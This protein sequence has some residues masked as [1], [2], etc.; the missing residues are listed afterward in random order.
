[1]RPARHG[2][3]SFLTVLKRLGPAGAGMMSFPMAGWTLSLDIPAGVPDL[4]PLLA[5]LDDLV[6]TAGGRVYLAK[7]SVLSPG[8]VARMYPQ[9]EAWQ[10]V[11]RRVDPAGI[12]R[13][14]LA[15]R[16]AI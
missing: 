16:L 4:G 13:S 14:D 5:E 11:R 7:D 6:V 15:R 8:L 2:L 12:M 9:L 1:M 3:P 10:R